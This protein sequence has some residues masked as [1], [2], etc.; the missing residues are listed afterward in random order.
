MFLISFKYGKYKGFQLMSQ[1][2]YD[3]YCDIMDRANKYLD[4]NMG[5][6][7]LYPEDGMKPIIISGSKAL[8]NYFKEEEFSIEECVA[9]MSL[10]DYNINDAYGFFPLDDIN[11]ALWEFAS[12]T[13]DEL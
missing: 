6:F 13:G 11:N 7:Y 2:R 3:N 12:I 5:K 9:L 4:Q 1:S 8:N 10:V